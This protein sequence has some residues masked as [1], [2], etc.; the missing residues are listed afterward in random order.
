MDIT[1][2]ISST[3]DVDNLSN[4]SDEPTVKHILNILT[5]ILVKKEKGINKR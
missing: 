1:Y 2:I 3:D 5:S 4:K